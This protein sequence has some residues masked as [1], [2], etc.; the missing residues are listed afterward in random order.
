[1]SFMSG[2]KIIKMRGG[3]G[4]G[5]HTYKVTHYNDNVLVFII[6]NFC[7]FFVQLIQFNLN[8]NERK[9]YNTYRWFEIIL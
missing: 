4:A 3:L 5:K 1:M 7:L 2:R 8:L 6:N 9:I